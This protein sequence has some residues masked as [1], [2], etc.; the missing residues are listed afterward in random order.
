MSGPV[1]RLIL[2][3][4]V[5]RLPLDAPA[6]LW[7]KQ[8]G[9]CHPLYGGNKARKA[10][11]LL[12]QAAQRGAR[13]VLTFGAAG[14]HHVLALSLFA[15][16]FGLE[17][18]AVLTPQPDTAHA[19]RVLARALSAGLLPYPARSPLFVPAALARAFR[20]GDRVIAPGGSSPHGARAYFDAIAEL[21]AQV[22]AGQLPEP[23]WLV[24]PLG[25]GGTVAGLLA[26]LSRSKLR[27][28]LLAVSVLSN[29]VAR[30]WVSWLARRVLRDVPGSK[31]LEN[32]RLI[33][34]GSEVGRGYGYA[35]PSGAEASRE[36]AHW[37]LEL[38]PTYTAKACAAALALARGLHRERAGDAPVLY[39]HT[40]NAVP[41]EDA[42]A[43]LPLAPE[44][45]R[46]FVREIGSREPL[47]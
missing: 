4:P 6:P 8:D 14:S 2:P 29:P 26:G 41:F 10:V 23:A 31:Q 42:A 38:D 32:A 7:L 5:V 18:A 30:P 46:L 35:S 28:R 11:R 19:R 9:H 47:G 45:E 27:S 24:A 15:P 1:S 20:S 36:A 13:R 37:G 22:T 25:S 44:L 21:E 12:E 34:D 39:W 33:I 16:E 43:P 17:V 40:L 3:T